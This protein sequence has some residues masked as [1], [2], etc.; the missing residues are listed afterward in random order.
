M[1]IKFTHKQ[2]IFGT[3]IYLNDYDISIASFANSDYPV[4][5]I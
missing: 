1:K 3:Y 5:T 2:I 4:K